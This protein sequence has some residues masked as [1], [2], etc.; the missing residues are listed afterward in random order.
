MAQSSEVIEVIPEV[1]DAELATSSVIER[2]LSDLAHAAAGLAAQYRPHEI[3]DVADYR[4]SKKARADANKDVRALK[5]RGREMTARVDAWSAGVK[6]AV[7]QALSPFDGMDDEYKAHILEF[8]DSVV[9]SRKAMMRERYEEFAPALALPAEGADAPLV[10]F[11]RIWQR[12]AKPQKWSNYGTNDEKAVRGMEAVVEGIAA[13]ERSI[14]ALVAEP[15]RADVKAL[16]FSTLDMDAAMA[17]A[18]ELAEARAMVAAMEAERAS[19][20]PPEA[21]PEADTEPEPQGVPYEKPTL[22]TREQAAVAQ[23]TRSAS[24]A[25]SDAP[26]PRPVDSQSVM[27]REQYERAYE[28]IHGAPAPRPIP[29]PSRAATWLFYCRCTPQQAGELEA[30]CQRLGIGRYM[31]R[32]GGTT[33]Y[34]LV[35][36]KE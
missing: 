9:E 18:G 31:A 16:Y 3:A 35:P 32:D 15:D 8:E 13:G 22:L 24:G 34:R 25:P 27:S 11:E 30:A 2:Q 19:W 12:H 36:A 26:A 17:R 1:I 28:D 20:Q 4:A 23:G 7:G 33:K 29:E 6:A 14:D 21:E 5:Q 10:P